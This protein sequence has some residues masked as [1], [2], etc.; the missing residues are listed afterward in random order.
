[1]KI[2]KRDTYIEEVNCLLDN[3]CDGNGI[4]VDVVT[5][6][7]INE[8]KYI[9]MFYRIVVKLLMIPY[10]FIDNLGIN[11]VVLKWFLTSLDNHYEEISSGSSLM[12]QSILFP[13]D[14][15]GKAP[16]FKKDDILPVREY[17][18]E[19]RKYFSYNDIPKMVWGTML[20]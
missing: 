6:G 8:N 15:L 11:P 1:M 7:S 12:S 19:G 10:V 16:V 18:F 4:F 9:D 3:K 17:E 13:W 2:R 5:Y 20:S 14:R